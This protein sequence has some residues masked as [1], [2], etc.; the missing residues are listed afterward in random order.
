MVMWI[1]LR[2]PKL[3]FFL[4]LGK[5]YN[6]TSYLKHKNTSLLVFPGVIT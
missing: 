5:I 4:F 6:K 3:S 1:T 2:I